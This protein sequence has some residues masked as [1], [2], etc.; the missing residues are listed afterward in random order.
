MTDH[1]LCSNDKGTVFISTVMLYSKI[2]NA[3]GVTID[4][5]FV[6]ALED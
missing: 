3:V 2:Y 4:D 5:N 6:T 1:C